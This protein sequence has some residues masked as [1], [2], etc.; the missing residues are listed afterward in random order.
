MSK[1]GRP[2]R[3]GKV[4]LNFVA[5]SF[6]NGLLSGEEIVLEMLVLIFIQVTTGLLSLIMSMAGS[7]TGK[8]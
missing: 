1:L 6:E 8:I 7:T 2:Q 5:E 3:P 4:S